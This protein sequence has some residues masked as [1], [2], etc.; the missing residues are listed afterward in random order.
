MCGTKQ[1]LKRNYGKGSGKDCRLQVMKLNE[2]RM[3][4]T[5]PTFDENMEMDEEEDKDEAI[6]ISFDNFNESF[7]APSSLNEAIKPPLK[8]KWSEFLDKIEESNE[9]VESEFEDNYTWE[10]KSNKRKKK[11]DIDK[12]QTK[13]VVHYKDEIIDYE[14][15]ENE[16]SKADFQCVKKEASNARK[17][18]LNSDSKWSK[19]SGYLENDSDSE[20]KPKRVLTTFNQFTDDNLDEILD[21]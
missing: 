10:M 8:S 17:R 5:E 12:I 9:D 19:Y 20:P 16:N 14:N 3:Q 4:Q 13:A 11:N 21:L 1:S 15:T 2:L 7:E 18:E 6:S